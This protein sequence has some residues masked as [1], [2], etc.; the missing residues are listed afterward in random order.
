MKNL[1]RHVLLEA[2]KVSE[3]ELKFE[4][5]VIGDL[6]GHFEAVIAS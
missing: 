2:A 6:R 4:V 5:M 3:A 1:S